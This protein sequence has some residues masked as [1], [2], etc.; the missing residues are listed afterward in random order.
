MKI[1]NIFTLALTITF[2][3]TSCSKQDDNGDLGGMWQL[4]EWK[5]LTDGSIVADKN[6]ALFYSVQLDL[7][8]FSIHNDISTYHLARFSHHND[9]LFIGDAYARPSETKVGYEDLQ[10][11]GV[12]P[13]GAFAID[14]LSHKNLILRTDDAI[15]RFRKY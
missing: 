7:M 9:S 13:S 10:K 4:T 5:S 15:L 8:K 14:H 6:D 2:T 11:Y 12:P 3:L 1:L